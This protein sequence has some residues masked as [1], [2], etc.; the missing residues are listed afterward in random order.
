M[1]VQTARGE[2]FG[3]G[4]QAVEATCTEAEGLKKEL[5]ERTLEY[6][7]LMQASDK[8]S[9][10][11]DHMHFRLLV[12]EKLVESLQTEAKLSAKKLD[13]TRAKFEDSEKTAAALCGKLKEATDIVACL[14]LPA[15]R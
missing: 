9:L 4:Q 1:V 12:S 15:L 5:G 14:P 7:I 10:K 13:F 6:K 2:G 3:E 11:A 8:R